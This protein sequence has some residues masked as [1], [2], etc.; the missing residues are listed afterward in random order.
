VTIAAL[1]VLGFGVLTAFAFGATFALYRAIGGWQLVARLDAH[2]FWIYPA[3]LLVPGAAIALSA[4]ARALLEGVTIAPAGAAGV[5]V[6]A[7]AIALG[8][9]QYRLDLLSAVLAKRAAARRDGLLKLLDGRE[10]AL[11]LFRPPLVALVVMSVVVAFA[12]EVLWRGYLLAYFDTERGWGAGATVALCAISYGSVHYYFG[13]RN[14][15]VKALHGAV[16]GVLVITGAG[17][18]AAAL[19]HATFELCVARGLRRAQTSLSGEVAHAA[20]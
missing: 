12:E 5:V 6:A 15:L 3:L 20:H 2:G 7:A 10:D 16:W 4:D 9:A 11:G 17:L 14:V 8:V 13:L 19:A 18:L 1:L